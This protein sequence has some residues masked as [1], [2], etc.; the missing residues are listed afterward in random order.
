MDLLDILLE[1]FSK[2]MMKKNKGV[3]AT[4]NRSFENKSGII[5]QFHKTKADYGNALNKNLGMLVRGTASKDEFLALQRNVIQSN[6]R[7][8]FLLGKQYTQTEEMELSPDEIK[9]LGY[10]IGQE[11]AFMSKFADDV[12]N[13]TGK[14]NYSRRMSM[15]AEGLTPLFIF[16]QMVYLPEGVKIHW[17]LGDTDKHC[18][19]CLSLAFN[20]PYE[21]KNLPTVP[22]GCSTQCLSNCRCMLQF[23]NMGP[24][25]DY[26]YYVMDKYSDKGENVPEPAQVI[27]LQNATIAF[28]FNRAVAHLEKDK[29]AMQRAK[30]EKAKF[31]SLI[32]DNDLTIKSDL[33]VATFLNDIDLF[34]KNKAFERIYF[35][36][37]KL[38]G[39]IVSV[40]RSGVQVY[41]VV[42]RVD[43]D[44]IHIKTL[45]NTRHLIHL[46]TSIVFKE[47]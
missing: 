10:Q 30:D 18:A 5:K 39:K 38:V 13:N 44:F 29:D 12:I 47:K 42:E 9:S 25:D 33:P 11:M 21:K 46:N 35:A 16:G 3:M 37:S 22:K 20:S 7:Q 45:Y 14:M 43:G 26:L 24:N 2:S 32:K 34:A 40:H 31:R 15:Y 6:F 36:N 28:Y 4:P 8:S 27:S 17:V 19:D 23:P 1:K 41:G